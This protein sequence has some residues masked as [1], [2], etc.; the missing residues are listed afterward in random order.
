MCNMILSILLRQLPVLVSLGQK[1]IYRKV[2]QFIILQVNLGVE[3]NLLWD[4]SL[5]IYGSCV[6]LVLHHK[7]QHIESPSIVLL[8]VWGL[9]KK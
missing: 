2:N 9:C 8:D 6:A 7:A 4:T 1:L 3:V 5:V